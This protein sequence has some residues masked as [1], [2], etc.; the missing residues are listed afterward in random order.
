MKTEKQEI[1]G[2]TSN[3]S[4]GGLDTSVTIRYLAER[5][6]EVH[7]GLDAWDLTPVRDEVIAAMLT[8]ETS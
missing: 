8:K 2:Q 6:Y 1:D 5:G 4:S 3:P 7:V